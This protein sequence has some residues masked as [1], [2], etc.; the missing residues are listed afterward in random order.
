M[1]TRIYIDNF[2]CF[3]N[4]EFK[5]RRKELIFG[6]NGTGKTVLCEVLRLLRDFVMVGGAT[7]G[8]FTEANRCRW[9]SLREQTFELEARIDEATYV[10][11]LRIEHKPNSPAPKVIQETVHLDQK[12]IFEFLDGEVHLFNDKL[13]HKVTYPFDWKQGA[14]STIDPRKDNLKLSRFKFWLLSLHCVRINP[15]AT[16]GHAEREDVF[17]LPDLTNFASWYRH[18]LQSQPVEAERFRGSVGQ[19]IDGFSFMRL[20]TAAEG[21]RRLEISF[22]GAAAR[23]RC[24]FEELSD[25]QRSLMGLYALLHFVV[26]AGHTVILDEPD[27]FVAI[28]EIQPWLMALSD[29]V[30]GG[31]GQVLIASH[32]PEII[33]RLAPSCG[34]HFVR[35]GLGPV[36]VQPFQPDPDTQLTTAEL[37][38][39]GWLD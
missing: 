9:S 14:L 23:Y 34:S 12:P 13:E 7:S 39:R 17:P 35:E 15:F 22:E 24:S 36:R 3:T 18:L 27:N 26:E 37:M 28:R 29:I 32:H 2:R 6:A 8:Y 1:L 16:Q 5:P 21:T 4:F 11:K 20:E 10:Y 19:A 33:N 25:G 38:A 30:D 31:S